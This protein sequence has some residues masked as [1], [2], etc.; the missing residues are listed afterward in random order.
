MSRNL[1]RLSQLITT[2]GPGSMLDLPT[3]SVMVGGLDRWEM[4]QGTWTPIDEPRLVEMLQRR[5]TSPGPNGEPPRMPEGT[6]LSL[7]TPPLA[8]DGNGFGEPPGVPVSVF[9]TWFICEKV[10]QAPTSGRHRRRLVRWQDLEPGQGRRYFHGDDG[11]RTEVTP[12]RFVGA[13]ERGHIQDIDWRWVLHGVKRC[14]EPLWLEERGTSADPA[15]TYIV[16]DC[17]IEPLSLQQAF[18]PGRLGRC[19]GERPWLGRDGKEECDKDLRLL[20][21]TATNTYFPQVATV[22]SLP[23]AEDELGKLLAAHA[24]DL[25]DAASPADVAQALK[26]NSRLREALKG[27]T[28]DDIFS[29][30]ELMRSLAQSSASTK[31][32]YAEFDI[33]ASGNQLIGENRHDAR[34]FAETLP[35]D[36]W[37]A[38]VGVDLG[39]IRSLVAVHRLREVM[40]LYG[41][42]RFEAAPTSSDG[43]IEDVRLTVGGAPL[44]LATDW[45]PAIEQFGEGL[46]IHVDP[47]AI[48]HW[49]ARKPVQERITV[50]LGGSAAWAHAKYGAHVP[51]LPGAAYFL[52]HTLSHAL[53]SE[54][55]LDC[56]YPASSLKERVY[57]LSDPGNPGQ[58]N[59]C[60]ILVYTA[61]AGSFGT[62]G[63]LVA[64]APRFAHILAAALG[65]LQICSNDPVCADHDPANRTDDRGLHGAACHGCLLIAETSCEMRNVFLDRA[66]IVETMAN[67]GASL[68]SG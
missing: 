55:A 49:L 30:L 20:T 6:R 32:K 40:C 56:G 15:D 27:W 3:R 39:F 62:L 17:N 68:F 59:R 67:G 12:I 7:R 63:G 10:E 18:A 48:G 61:T 57:A 14:Q 25:K 45:L 5:L 46:F 21:R 1:Q 66:L 29:R 11:K 13:C 28:P 58:V 64:T 4:R 37:E 65:R 35:R 44:G 47:D 16:C 19:A 52:L 38:S 36:T 42:T 26:F 50:L 24:D 60:G 43:D 33:L 2:F 54:I 41:F 31:P 34:L 9:P 8:K 51:E 53:I 22:I 23:A